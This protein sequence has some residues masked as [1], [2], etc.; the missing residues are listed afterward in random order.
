MRMTI[1]TAGA[2]RC[3]HVPR[4]WNTRFKAWIAGV[5]TTVYAT[6]DGE[7]LL[8]P[9]GR[10]GQL[11]LRFTQ[12][13]YVKYSALLSAVALVVLVLRFGIPRKKTI[14]TG[15]LRPL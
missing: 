6:A 14:E 9:A 13:G 2:D 4:Y 10:S 3:I 12:P 11:H 7:I 8:A 15:G 5:E 1:T